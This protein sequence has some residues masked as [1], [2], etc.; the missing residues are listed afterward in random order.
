MTAK[1]EIEAKAKELVAS[2][3]AENC[4]EGPFHIDADFAGEESASVAQA[5]AQKFELRFSKNGPNGNPVVRGRLESKA[6]VL[7]F[8]REYGS[9][10]VFEPRG[11]GGRGCNV[12]FE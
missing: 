12:Y 5:M 11:A 8:A 2:L 4:D 1:P 9:K 3:L 10:A 6:K 7:A